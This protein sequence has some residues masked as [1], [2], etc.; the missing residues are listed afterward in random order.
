[1]S[2]IDTTEALTEAKK[3]H[4]AGKTVWAVSYDYENNCSTAPDVC[5]GVPYFNWGPGILAQVQKAI[6]GKFTQDWQWCPR[7]G[8]ISIIWILP[9]PVSKR[10]TL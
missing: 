2:G 9:R 4:D 10:A 5:L 3:F 6:A 8:R 1:M 7:I